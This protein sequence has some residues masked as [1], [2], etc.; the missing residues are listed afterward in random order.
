MDEQPHYPPPLDRLFQM[1][2]VEWGVEWQGTDP[3]YVHEL[4]LTAEHVPDLVVIARKQVD[5]EDYPD[6]DSGWAPVHAWRALGQLR[7]AGAVEPL[8]SMLT[9]LTETGDDYHMY[10]FPVVFGM[11]GPAAI[12]ALAAYLRN[13]EHPLYARIT[14]ADGLCN[15][16]L[17]HPGARGEALGPLVEQ[18]GRYPENR[19]E[20]NGFLIVQLNRL[21]AVEAAELIERAFASNRVD[22]NICGSWG[23]IRDNLGVPGLGLV[24]DG[25]PRPAPTSTAWTPDQPLSPLARQR[26]HE[27]E[28]KEKA[29]RKQQD[30]T[31]KRNR[32]RR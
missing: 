21:K 2:E 11:I 1:G 30:K 15:V 22:K 13:V 18:L 9:V 7:A 16:G 29:K 26:R 12:S 8:L 20:L 14:A 10:D 27:K 28:K 4:G 24:P 31:K 17:R 6:E 19:Y 3:D 25:P 5:L 32:K 23:D